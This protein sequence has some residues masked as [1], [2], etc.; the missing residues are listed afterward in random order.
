MA[1]IS[2]ICEN[3]KQAREFALLGNYETALVYYQFVTGHIQRLLTT[4]TDPN[5]KQRWQE[6]R[7][8]IVQ[9]YEHV[10]EIS[11]ILASFKTDNPSHPSYPRDDRSPFAKKYEEPTRDPD[12]W[13]PPNRDPDVWPPPTPVEHRPSPNIRG[14]RPQ[15][16]GRNEPPSRNNRPAAKPAA[17]PAAP[18]NRQ[19]RPA[20]GGRDDR[21]DDRKGRGPSRDDRPVK[22]DGKKGG[23]CFDDSFYM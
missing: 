15:P 21:R 18:S 19:N 3:T 5:R 11:G 4:I 6:V 16:K 20:P 14:G 1:S 12:V 23:M 8:D 9:E 22:G 13:P 2:E 10:K 17:K 7:Q